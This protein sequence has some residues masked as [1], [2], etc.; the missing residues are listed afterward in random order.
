[1]APGI[2]KFP[3]RPDHEDLVRTRFCGVFSVFLVSFVTL[4]YPYLQNTVQ[5]ISMNMPEEPW[6]KTWFVL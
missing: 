5:P 1:V 4:I 2:C 3:T 6:T